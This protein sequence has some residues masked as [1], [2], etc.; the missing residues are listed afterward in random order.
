MCIK[1]TLY[2]HLFRELNHVWDGNIFFVLKH[3]LIIDIKYTGII[4]QQINY[5][6]DVLL[7][8][9]ENTNYPETTHRVGLPRAGKACEITRIIK[10]HASVSCALCLL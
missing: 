10:E 8:T 4:L 2:E 3:D 9:K 6:T 1:L 7:S 5:N